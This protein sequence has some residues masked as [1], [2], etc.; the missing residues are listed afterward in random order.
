M[1]WKTSR[2]HNGILPGLLITSKMRKAMEIDKN[3]ITY[4]KKKSGTN[5]K[6]LQYQFAQ[7]IADYFRKESN[8]D[9]MD[10]KRTFVAEVPPELEDFVNE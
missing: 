3:I 9:V 6:A 5:N 8:R 10:R 7:A 2:R 1:A 4:L